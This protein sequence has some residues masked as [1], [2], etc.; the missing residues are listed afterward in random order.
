MSKAI[1]PDWIRTIGVPLVGALAG[2]LLG[3]SVGAGFVWV[4]IPA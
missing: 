4:R 1:G 3:Y 2:V